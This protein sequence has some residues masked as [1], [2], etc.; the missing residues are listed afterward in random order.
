MTLVCLHGA[1]CTGAVFDFLRESAHVD[2]PPLPASD[3]VEAM[4]EDVI[5]YVERA[6]L[7][8]VVLC[9]HS[10]GA[11]VALEIALRA[12]QWLNGVAMLG[13]GLHLAVAPAIFQ[14]LETDFESASHRIA[15]Y[16]FAD[17]NDDRV[18]DIARSIRATGAQT[19]IAAFRACDAYD[20]GPRIAG[21]KVPLLAL[22]GELDRMTP[23]AYASELTG[24]VPGAEARIVPGAGH[25]VM[26]EAPG[27]TNEALRSFVSRLDRKSVSF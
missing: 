18:A 17:R 20:A 23:P 14:M 8:G 22:T 26:L 27:D 21:L 15:G 2:T 19:V 7:K 10:L 25:M 24:R 4:A 12:P 6:N 11:M 3:S 13:G 16:M 5:A 9:G 1:G